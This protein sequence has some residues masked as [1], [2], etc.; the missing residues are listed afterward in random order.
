M[1]KSTKRILA[2]LAAVAMMLSLAACAPKNGETQQEQG[3]A[4]DGAAFADS[5]TIKMMVSSSASWPYDKDWPAWKVIREKSGANLEISAVPDTDMATKIPL[6]MANPDDFPDLIF[7]NGNKSIADEYGPMGALVPLSDNLDKMPNFTAFWDTIPEQE[8]ESY[9]VQKSSGDG[10]MYMTPMYGKEGIGDSQTWM[11]RKDIFEKHNLK[12]PKTMDELYEVCKKLK[13]LYP[14]SYPFC[15]R[16]GVHRFDSTGHSFKQHMTFHPYYNYNTGKW[17]FGP[18]Q[19]EFKEMV[20]FYSKMIAEGLMTDFIS[21]D[22]KSWE[23]LMSNDRGFITVDFIVRIDNFQSSVRP[24]NPEYTLAIMEP[25]AADNGAGVNKVLRMYHTLS[26]YVVVNTK[27]EDRINN[28]LKFID[29]MYSPEGIEAT[30]WGDEG[31]TYKVENGERKWL[32][33]E[34]EDPVTLLGISTPGTQLCVEKAGYDALYSKEQVDNANKLSEYLNDYPSPFFTMAFPDEVEDERTDIW[35]SV[36][37]Y[38]SEM[39]SKFML[40]QTPMSEWDGFVKELDELGVD[41][42]LEIYQET[43]DSMK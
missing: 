39:L 6:I 16:M 3:E 9:F 37:G 24:Q 23:E 15:N 27:S 20:E 33:P 36:N 28:A 32:I 10:K 21:I 35:T 40:G 42:L 38:C 14:D 7:E 8:R 18:M 25:P 22:A 5:P 12:T 26:G 4:G 31:V 17:E 1:K 34:G 13:E 11:Y 30:T 2:I 41:R 43:Y 29:W 19:P